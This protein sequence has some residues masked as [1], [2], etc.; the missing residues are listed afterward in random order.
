[1]AWKAALCDPGRPPALYNNRC[2]F[3]RNGKVKL[4]PAKK[5]TPAPP[6]ADGVSP[7][8]DIVFSAVR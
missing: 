2:N 5:I 7:R 6:A 8:L 1:M 3:Q 4:R